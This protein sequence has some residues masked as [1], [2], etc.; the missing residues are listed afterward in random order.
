MLI[1]AVT[2][3]DV[4]GY[5]NV[6]HDEDDRLIEGITVASKAFILAYTGIAPELIDGFEDLTIA[7]L[8]LCA[9]MYD[10]RAV[11][12]ESNKIGF[13]IKQLLDSHSI[14]LI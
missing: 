2:P 11:T 6:F 1:S 5:L 14:N 7:L 3:A 8:I 10:N 4:K 9:E 13:V 12:V